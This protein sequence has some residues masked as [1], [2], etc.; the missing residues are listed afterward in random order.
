[1]SALIE[2]STSTAFLNE[3]L[4]LTKSLFIGAFLRCHD[5][6]GNTPRGRKKRDRAL[7][8]RRWI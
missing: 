8:G 7:N 4:R 3:V 1:L 6:G 5:L 2:C